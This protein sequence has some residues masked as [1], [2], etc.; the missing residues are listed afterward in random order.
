MCTADVHVLPP[1]SFNSGGVEASQA[2]LRSGMQTSLSLGHRITSGPA[3]SVCAATATAGVATRT[4]TGDR[5][6]H[7]DPLHQGCGECRGHVLDTS[8]A[9]RTRCGAA[10]QRVHGTAG[11]PGTEVKDPP[12]YRLAGRKA[13]GRPAGR[14]CC[15]FWHACCE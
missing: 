15:V 4:F 3:R 10:R 1:R 5:H 9:K 8:P 14:M 2:L 12:R 11:H 13:A 6:R 7:P